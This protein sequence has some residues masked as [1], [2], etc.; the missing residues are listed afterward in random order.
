MA[1]LRHLE[2]A[3]LLLARA[4]SDRISAVV[5]E[6]F[7]RAR[8]RFIETNKPN[9]P[10]L[11]EVAQQKPLLTRVSMNYNP[12]IANYTRLSDIQLGKSEM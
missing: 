11:S 7:A 1:L 9:L 3:R 4:M 8:A 6:N 12:R 5:L 2:P 10:F